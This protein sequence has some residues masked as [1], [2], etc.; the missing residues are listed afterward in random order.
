M[1]TLLGT[2]VNVT[3]LFAVEAYM[4]VAQA[5][6][7]GLERLRLPAI[8]RYSHAI[9]GGSIALCGSAISFLGL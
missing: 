9:A 3:L 5:Y 2:C 7:A 6:M 4:E 1:N 8:G